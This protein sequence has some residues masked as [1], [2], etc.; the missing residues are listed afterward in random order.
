MFGQDDTTQQSRDS[1]YSDSIAEDSN[2][3]FPG[4][5]D[6]NTQLSTQSQDSNEGDTD[7]RLGMT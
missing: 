3:S 2:M 7:M 4:G 5:T 1:N 6:N